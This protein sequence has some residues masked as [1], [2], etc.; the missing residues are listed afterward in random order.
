MNDQFN[1]YIQG[2]LAVTITIGFFSVI[3]VLFWKTDIPGPVKDILL[4]ML[5][6]LLASWKEITGYF[7]GSSSGS[8]RKD[9]Q[10]AAI[11][12]P[13]GVVK[14]DDAVPVKVEEVKP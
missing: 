5:G 13:A 12:A 10:L 11:A 8:A 4:V 9:A 6:A 2:F 14:I 3:G 1:K 7:F